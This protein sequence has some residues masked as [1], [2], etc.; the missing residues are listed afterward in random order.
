MNLRHAVGF[1]LVGSVLAL[2]PRIA[3]GW[4][5]AGTTGAREAWLQM[6]S[7]IQ[8]GMALSHFARRG[9]RALV[10]LMEYNPQQMSAAVAVPVIGVLAEASQVAIRARERARTFLPRPKGLKTGLLQSQARAA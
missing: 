7:L 4:C 5:V 3:P 8:I 2:I 6:M 9:F 1:L 10:A